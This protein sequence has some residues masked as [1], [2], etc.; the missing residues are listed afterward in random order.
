[1]PLRENQAT[2]TSLQERAY[3]RHVD[4]L[5]L[6]NGAGEAHTVGPSSRVTIKAGGEE[7]AGTFYLGE[8]EIEPGFPG[9]P[10]H[11]H[12]ALHDMFYV[13]RGRLT[14]QLGDRTVEATP[15]TFICVPP[16]VPHTFSNRSD[17]PV[18]FLNF[19]TPSGWER[20]MRELGAAFASGEP[21]TPEA[22]G[23]IASRYDFKLSD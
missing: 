5:V 23:R 14:V 12:E 1:M 17:Q 16:G 20:Y 8:S 7:T 21:L 15:G 10:L 22:I 11:F 6:A 3:T 13:L 9:P 2:R 19:N 18:Q 4:G